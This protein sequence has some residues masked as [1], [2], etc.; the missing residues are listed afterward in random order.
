MASELVSIR[1]VGLWTAHMHLIFH[2]GSPDVLPVGDLGIKK[3][4]SKLF[5]SA[6]GSGGGGG[7]GGGAGGGGGGGKGGKGGKGGAKSASSSSLPTEA[8]M[9]ELAEPF[10]PHRSLLSY[11][12]WRAAG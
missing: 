3:G 12:L 10:R 5:G 4:F 11:Y 6:A 9:L 7:G 1:G 8:S 2:M